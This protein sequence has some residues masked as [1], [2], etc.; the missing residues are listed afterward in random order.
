[1][2]ELLC[3]HAQHNYRESERVAPVK[4]DQPKDFVGPLATVDKV[5]VEFSAFLAVRQG[6]RNRDEHNC[7]REDLAEH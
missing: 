4:D 2:D 6:M 5:P 3:D 1:V 7:V